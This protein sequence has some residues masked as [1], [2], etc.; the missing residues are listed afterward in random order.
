MPHG[1]GPAPSDPVAE[2]SGPIPTSS[3]DVTCGSRQSPI[4]TTGVCVCVCVR[5]CYAGVTA[6]LPKAA[7]EL[8]ALFLL[9]QKGA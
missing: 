5:V 3:C 2:P 8:L 4:S 9:T 6:G 1:P 7:A